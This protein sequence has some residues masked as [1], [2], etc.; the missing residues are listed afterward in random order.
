[1]M[2]KTKVKKFQFKD[3]TEIAR[4]IGKY[5]EGKQASAVLALLDLAQREHEQ[6]HYV[7]DEAFCEIAKILAM[8]EIRVREVA[9]FFTMINT[10]P[11]GKYH[12]Q[13]CGTTPCMLCGAGKLKEFIT[14]KLDVQI[15][16]TT[17]D[18]MFTVTEVECLGACVNAPVMQ[19]NDDYY[20]D[21]TPEHIS[22][23]IDS[24]RRGTKPEIGSAL[25]RLN[26][27]PLDFVGSKR[28]KG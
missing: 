27:A 3:K 11:V 15:G 17:R 28:V 4:A 2:T 18:G 10:K 9:S 20:E 12:L 19:V 26:S 6:G 21:L 22:E 5:P 14:K 16:E 23:I 24:F 7:T 13:L 25:G 8:P 1:M